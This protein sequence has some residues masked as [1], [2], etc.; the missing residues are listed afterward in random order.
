MRDL[1]CLVE[2]LNCGRER[3]EVGDG[4]L[5]EK[6]A[7]GEY[8]ASWDLF[9]RRN[10]LSFELVWQ[11]KVSFAEK[12]FVLRY[13]ILRSVEFA[14]VTHH[15]VEHYTLS[16]RNPRYCN[17]GPPQSRLTPKEASRIYPS[18][19]FDISTN[20]A[21][22]LYRRRAGHVPRQQNVEVA[23]IRLTEALVEVEDLLWRYLGAFHLPVCKVVTC[24]AISTLACSCSPGHI[25]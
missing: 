9:A 12:R 17:Q 14:I 13:L 22:S 7:L 1:V 8:I 19:E 21:H 24:E 23:Q 25:L 11:Y 4:C 5:G 2:D 20:L 18:I 10:I 16:A 3:I 6:P 15:R